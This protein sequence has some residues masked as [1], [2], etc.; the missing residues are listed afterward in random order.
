MKG[1]LLKQCLIVEYKLRKRK[2][3]LGPEIGR[4]QRDLNQWPKIVTL[5]E[6][7]SSGVRLFCIPIVTAS[8]SAATVDSDCDSDIDIDSLS[9]AV[10][11]GL[12]VSSKS[13][14]KK[15]TWSMWLQWSPL[16]EYPPGQNG[17]TA[18]PTAWI[19]K[20]SESAR[21]TV[22]E[23]VNTKIV[24]A[25]RNLRIAMPA[26]SIQ[27]SDWGITNWEAVFKT[28]FCVFCFAIN[29]E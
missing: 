5:L 2:L 11:A 20:C 21:P 23:H 27:I 26:D 4:K 28:G 18:C 19:P 14:L 24:A 15:A 16:S 10:A 7:G 1:G 8:A 17:S 3:N 29:G 22:A 12:K 25:H 9:T 6:M 13:S